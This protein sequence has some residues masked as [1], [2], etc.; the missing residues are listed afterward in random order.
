MIQGYSIYTYAKVQE[1][2]SRRPFCYI[3]E[4]LDYEPEKYW[5]LTDPDPYILEAIK[6]LGNWTEPFEYGNSTFWFTAIWDDPDAPSEP[7]PIR[8]VPFKYNGTYYEYMVCYPGERLRVTILYEEPEEYWNLTSPDRYLLEAIES[9][10]KT[11][12]VGIDSKTSEIL[13]PHLWPSTY[14]PFCY[15]GTYYKYDLAEIDYSIPLPRSPKPELT[16]GAL[17]TVWVAVGSVYILKN[18][19]AKVQH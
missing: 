7:H 8:P 19:K 15:N 5:N 16:A 12:V 18:K 1:A 10:G 9:P 14:K 6:H 13:G 3:A 17:A 2:V 11:I 4:P